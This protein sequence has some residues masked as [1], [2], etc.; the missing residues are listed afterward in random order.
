MNKQKY[1]C[2]ISDTDILID[3]FKSD[4]LNI[5]NVLF[6]KIYITEYIYEK[7]LKRV[8]NRLKIDFSELDQIITN[9]DGI[10]EIIYD[11]QLDIPVKK[12][13][14][15]IFKER[16]I[17]VGAGEA[18]CAAYSHA[19]GINFVVSNNH[20]EFEFLNDICIMLSYTHL[21]TISCLHRKIT[22]D[23]AKNIYNKVNSKKER[24][25]SH[26]FRKKFEKSKQYIKE[27]NY[28]KKLDLDGLL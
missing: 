10:F 5:L 11:D 13:K 8:A 14:K 16:K 26:S 9:P 22:F 21:L 20:T 6:E 19:S 7:E 4:A 15:I 3:L 25:S 17:Y 28:T 23:T 24:P 27:N 2:A 12:V 18:D 1:R